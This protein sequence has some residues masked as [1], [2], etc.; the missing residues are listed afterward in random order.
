MNQH[1]DTPVSTLPCQKNSQASR[2]AIWGPLLAVILFSGTAKATPDVEWPVFGGNEQHQRHSSADQIN[3]EN[4][5]KLE[6]AWELDTGVSGSFQATPIVKDGVMYMSLPF[7]HVLAVDA[8]TGK[9][10]W[11]Y[12]HERIKSR[13]MCCGPAN[14]G[15]AV[16]NGKVFMGTV[17]SRLIA[18]DARSGKKLWDTDVLQGQTSIA[19]DISTLQ[20]QA[21]GAISGA[22]GTGLIMAPMVYKGKVII[23]ITGVG[24]GLHLDAPTPNAPLG[25]VFGIAGQYG[26]RGFLA[27]YDANT[28]QQTWKFDTVPDKGWE[29]AFTTH[30]EDGVKLPRN[31]EEEKRKAPNFSD[32][33]KYGGGSAWTTPAIDHETGIL[34]FGTGNPSPQLEDS[35]RPGDNLYTTS[36]VAL[37]ANTGERKWHYQ[38]VPH[39][40]WGYDV[41]SPPVLFTFDPQGQKIPAVGQ[42]GKTGWFY[43]H[44][45]QTGKLLLKSE[46]FVP[47]WNIFE[48]AT[49]KGITIYP[50]AVGG[51]NWSPVALDESKRRV[52][53][54]GIHWPV[55]YKLHEIAA[56][57]G[58]PAVKYSSITL[59]EDDERYGVLSSIDLDSGKLKWQYKTRNPLI[60]GVLSTA[61]GLVFVGLGEGELAAYHSDTGAKLWAGKTDAGANAPPVTYVLDGKQYVAVAAGGNKLFGFKG[62]QKIHVWALGKGR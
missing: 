4:V 2:R 24:Y 59:K 16:E 28:G 44:D 47:Q 13:P 7:N 8:R 3:R 35:T 58:K 17:D 49:E 36:L 21:S 61:G 55:E 40:L 62:G 50:G 56:G 27:A 38:Q 48:M 1:P 6:P 29:G 37:D 15:V 53:V 19:E 52:F 5:N 31:I 18:L 54:A 25:S 30:T 10:L 57:E 46:A 14:R 41:A 9:T 32:A 42:A 45:R 60:G 11:R 12:T 33:W 34:Y 20:G 51:S 26:T 43:I 23:G 22:S 39:D